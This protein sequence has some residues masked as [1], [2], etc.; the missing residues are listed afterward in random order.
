MEAISLKLGKFLTD[1]PKSPLFEIG[2][3][4]FNLVTP[5]VATYQFNNE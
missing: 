2:V 4:T 5:P 1:L 3:A